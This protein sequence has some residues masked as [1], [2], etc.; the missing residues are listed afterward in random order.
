MA[1]RRFASVLLL[2]FCFLVSATEVPQSITVEP[3]H[4]V[5]LPCTFSSRSPVMVTEWTRRGL[6][7]NY[8]FMY[9]DGQ[10]DPDQQYPSFKNRVEMKDK[11]MKNGDLS[12]ILKNVTTDDAGTYECHVFQPER[13]REKRATFDTE[14]IK[15]INLTV[16]PGQSG[17][18]GLAVGLSAAV[19]LIV[20]VAGGFVIYRKRQISKQN[21]N[22]D[23]A[24][25][26]VELQ[27]MQHV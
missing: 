14:P 6:E 5:I 19:V 9:R 27:L 10:Y 8:V 11:Q 24:V 13:N 21:S 22:Q 4:D 20:A 23:S 18:V 7:P 26:A 2:S 17:N 15:I 25:E 12:L 1:Q 3:G 16:E